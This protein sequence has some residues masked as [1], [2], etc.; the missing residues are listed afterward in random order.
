MTDKDKNL[1]ELMNR[2]LEAMAIS[3]AVTLNPIERIHTIEALCGEI[4]QLGYEH[5]SAVE[6]EY[7]RAL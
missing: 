3:G 5:G 1:N 7:W 2:M 4:Y 6:S